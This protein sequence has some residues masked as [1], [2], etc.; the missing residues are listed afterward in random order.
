M[1]QHNIWSWNTI[2]VEFMAG[3]KQEKINTQ[4]WMPAQYLGN[5][6]II[7]NITHP[8]TCM[9]IWYINYIVKG[10][11]TTDFY[12]HWLCHRMNETY[13]AVANTPCCKSAV[14]RSS[15]FLIYPGLQ[16]GGVYTLG[17]VTKL[18]RQINL[19]KKKK[20]TLH[21]LFQIGEKEAVIQ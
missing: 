7:T 5:G 10:F 14:F 3:N 1:I 17:T 2:I 16:L 4:W 13:C 6:P 21:P 15:M 11:I 9:F 8:Y 19:L 18:C 20:K 12:L